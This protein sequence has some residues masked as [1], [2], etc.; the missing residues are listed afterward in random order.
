MIA[1]EK[2][3]LPLAKLLLESG[4]DPF[5]WSNDAGIRE[6]VIFP[7]SAVSRALELGHRELLSLFLERLNRDADAI[8]IIAS[9]ARKASDEKALEA[10]MQV[11]RLAP[12]H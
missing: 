12:S 1:T 7:R 11:A 6:R 5:E 3:N 2:N 10:V 8:K 9:A 4:A